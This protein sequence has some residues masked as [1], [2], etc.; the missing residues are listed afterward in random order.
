MS[1]ST[2]SRRCSA[3]PCPSPLASQSRRAGGSGRAEG[4]VD[5]NPGVRRCGLIW[6]VEREHLGRH[7]GEVVEAVDR[8]ASGLLRRL[9]LL[10]LG[11]GRGRRRGLLLLRP[12]RGLLLL[13]PRSGLLLLGSALGLGT[14]LLGL[15]P[16]C[17]RL[18]AVL[19]R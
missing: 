14:E 15:L 11:A 13:R 10:L 18:L 16:R 7:R 4:V 19:G 3:P 1:S 5:T 17:G 2:D 9:G 12:R 8:R 6:V